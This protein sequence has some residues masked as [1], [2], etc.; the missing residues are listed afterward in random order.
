MQPQYL[1]LVVGRLSLASDLGVLGVHD[2]FAIAC[3]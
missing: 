2:E 3:G 1:V